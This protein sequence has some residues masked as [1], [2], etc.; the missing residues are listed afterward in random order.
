MKKILIILL[1]LTVFTSLCA[2]TKPSTSGGGGGGGGGPPSCSASL[3]LTRTGTDVCV[4]TASIT[5]SN[6]D[7]KSY[8]IKNGGSKCSGTI[9]GISFS[10]ECTWSTSYGDY[11]YS[12]YIDGQF[13]NSKS[14]NCPQTPQT[15]S[16]GTY[17]G[18]CSPTKPSY[19]S[20]G[21]LIDKCSVCGCP[22]GKSCNTTLESCYIPVQQCS[23][24]TRYGNC[25]VAKPKYCDN[26]NLVNRC[27]V[28]GC[29]I[30]Q[31]CNTTNEECYT[32][33]ACSGSV[34]LNLSPS[35]VE[36][37]GLVTPSA[38]NLT[39]CDNKIIYFKKDSCTGTQMSF[40]TLTGDG[41][42]GPDFTAPGSYGMYTY[43]AC[44]DKNGDGDFTESGENSSK[45][46]N[47]TD[48]TPF[49]LQSEIG[50]IDNSLEYFRS[51]G[52]GV[53]DMAEYV[54]SKS[55]LGT[56]I[57]DKDQ[58][59]NY[60]D[61]AQEADGSWNDAWT[62]MFTTYR[63]LMAYQILNANP[64]RSLDTFFNNYDSWSEALNYIS[65]ETKTDLRDI[66]HITLAW[67]LYYGAYP[68]WLNDYFSTVENS[69]YIGWTNSTEVHKRTHILYNYV[70]ARRQFPNLDGIINE[71]LREQSAN[72]N[73]TSLCLSIPRPVYCN[74]IQLVLLQQIIKLY[75]T[76]RT[77]EI[78]NSMDKSRTW[79]F[80]TYNTATV[81][82]IVMGRFGTSTTIEDALMTG[83]IA[84]G[85]NGLM[86]INVDMTFSDILP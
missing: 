24:G 47:V 4:I 1:I 14:V 39:S 72:G 85:I 17:Y 73:W 12:L 5:A 35:N 56:Q 79:V 86:D 74:S 31:N 6:C 54:I 52:M 29:P 2:Q 42:T 64:N 81:N 10:K 16:D 38:S 9:A 82:G 55:Y 51:K 25:S 80:D 53:H 34:M 67:T 36:S 26:G 83:I 63:V 77:A 28:C 59:I 84:A 71:T 75:P 58:I 68:S 65:E 21:N 44:I 76:Y 8:E 61:A 27:D 43:Y 60:F 32:P 33:I 15:C 46:L 69:T 18:S 62:P 70:I 19:C 78:Q 48:F 3:S 49:L 40:C 50:H 57:A 45:L 23:D 37:G 11:T 41:C 20:N 30:N 7:N 66:Y 13:K 22:A